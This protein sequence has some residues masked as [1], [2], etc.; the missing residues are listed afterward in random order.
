[1]VRLI[2]LCPQPSAVRLDN[3]TAD[4]QPHTHPMRFRRKERLEYLVG[5][6]DAWA[7]ITD[8][9]LDQIALSA[10]AKPEE[11]VPRSRVHCIHAVADEIDENLLNLDAIER[12]KWKVAF[13]INFHANAT[14]LCLVSHKVPHFRNDVG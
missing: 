10:H 8:F 4:R 13:D 3:R 9:G 6:L 11:S 14:T 1:S 2:P 12:D 5:P 7:A